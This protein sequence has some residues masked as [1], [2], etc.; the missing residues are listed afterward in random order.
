MPNLYLIK[1]PLQLLNAIEAS[2]R[3]PDNNEYLVIRLTDNQRSNEQIINMLSLKKWANIIT[4]GNSRFGLGMLKEFG[5]LRSLKKLKIEFD[6]IFIGDY[7]ASNYLIFANNL[8]CN[9]VVLLDDGTITYLIQDQYILENKLYNNGFKFELIRNILVK[10]L[11]LRSVNQHPINLFTCYNIIPAD[12]QKIYSN[13]YAFIKKYIETKNFSLEEE[14]VFFVGAKYSEIGW[15]SENDYF[16]VFK[17]TLDYYPG[18]NIVYIPHRGEN[19]LKLN[20]LASQFGVEI[21]KF[22]LPIELGILEDTILPRHIIGFTSSALLNIRKMYPMI[23]IVSYK[24]PIELINTPF[25]E[26]IDEFY[27]QFQN[28]EGLKVIELTND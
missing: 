19:D 11:G 12:S 5:V 15:M 6:K 9:E 3:F 14:L 4:V 13:D 24:V 27:M 21:R 2:T 8:P 25:S 22:D 28:S 26:I 18:H 20:K 1:S 16:D 10:I 7:R 23:K 17:A